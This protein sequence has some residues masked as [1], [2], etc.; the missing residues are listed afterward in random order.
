MTR[1]VQ[2]EEVRRIGVAADHA[3]F[4]LKTRLVPV[5]EQEGYEVVDYGAHEN[6]ANDDY[7]DFVG[8]LAQGVARG[9]VQRG[10]A[11]CGSGVGASVAANKV[12]GA[13]AATLH[14]IF[15][16][17]QGVEDDDVN[18]MCLGGR[19]IGDATALELV[20]AFLTARFIGA[21]RHRRRLDK[22]LELERKAGM[23]E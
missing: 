7:P 9:E 16:A 18:I 6:D 2:I 10:I 12:A 19:V 15:S 4:E 8:P 17:R 1:E 22:V 13:R 21:E 3:G 20:R 23:R 5:L 14:D 11:C